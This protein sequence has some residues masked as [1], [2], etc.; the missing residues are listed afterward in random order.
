M[1]CG[2]LYVVLLST[3][4]E[5]VAEID[6]AITEVRDQWH[7]RRRYVRKYRPI[8]TIVQP[9][10]DQLVVSIGQQQI[11]VGI[12]TRPDSVEAS[13]IAGFCRM[14][15]GKCQKIR[16]GSSPFLV[17]VSLGWRRRVSHDRRAVPKRDPGRKKVGGTIA[18]V[19]YCIWWCV[20]FSGPYHS[21]HLCGRLARERLRDAAVAMS[22]NIRWS[23]VLFG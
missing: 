3:I 4:R 7:G 8:G 21:I 6:L 19:L 2:I 11:W 13:H 22:E 15:V 14:C 5:L 18:T 16:F 20:V 12:T 1:L 10:F 23:P 9:Y 17:I